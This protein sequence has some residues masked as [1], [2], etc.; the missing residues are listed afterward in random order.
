MNHNIHIISIYILF[1]I[2]YI[3]YIYSI[4][5]FQLNVSTQIQLLHIHAVCEMV[6]STSNVGYGHDDG[7]MHVLTL[8]VNP[9]NTRSLSHHYHVRV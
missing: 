2:Y 9:R 8:K 7:G 1:I 5:L 4:N 3:L 6:P